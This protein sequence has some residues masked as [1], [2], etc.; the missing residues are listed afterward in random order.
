MSGDSR[1]QRIVDTA[2]ELAE[3]DGYSAV[4]LRDIAK[5]AGV[6]LGTV[7]SRFKSK[8]DIL[9]AVMSSEGERVFRRVVEQTAGDSPVERAISF[10]DLA[11]AAIL[12]RPK[13]ARAMLRSLV[14]EGDVA[15]PVS[16][17][18]LKS[19]TM[20]R[21]LIRDDTRSEE[22]LW[23]IATILQQVWFASLIGWSGGLYESRDEVVRHVS[24]AARLLLT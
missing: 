19:T 11:S 5:K 4:R 22:Q 9:V 15:A 21:D 14:G 3:S 24:D 20:L 8:E 12:G 16:R 18:Q 2:I 13:L 10:F 1:R 17:L 7:Y 23:T 6:A